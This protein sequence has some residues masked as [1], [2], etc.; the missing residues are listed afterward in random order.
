[1][2]R[3]LVLLLV[4]IV[5]LAPGLFLRDPPV[6]PNHSQSI[7]AT[8]LIEAPAVL[9]PDGRLKLTGAWHLTS[10]NDDFGS[11]SALVVLDDGSLLAF[12]DRGRY[13]RLPA[14]L[15]QSGAAEMGEVFP[16]DEDYK[17]L[18]DIEAAQRDPASGRI[19]LGLE[20]RN[21]ILR[22]DADFGSIVSSAPEAIK[23]WP[24][25]GGVEAMLRTTDDHWI[26]IGEFWGRGGGTS[27]AVVFHGDPVDN[28]P[29]DVF[30][31][32]P[33]PGQYVSDMALLPDGRA[34][35]LSRGAALGWPVYFPITL[36]VAD[37]Q[38][39]LPGTAWEWEELLEL[40]GPVPNENYEGLAVTGGRDGE[41]VTIWLIS[42]DNGSQLIQQT[43]LIRLEWQP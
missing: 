1:V 31:F 34:L 24:V 35:I 37:Q 40:G 16:G 9:D 18:Q 43:R 15:L 20:A 36:M 12:S 23:D 30:S 27:E 7:T 13:L 3:R 11:Y 39:I 33:P 10:D 19:W 2:K 42:D 26:V 4:V 38:T 21:A 25:N 17:P 32:V 8:S 28:A 14:P 5:G 6:Q 29:T 41:P 22:M